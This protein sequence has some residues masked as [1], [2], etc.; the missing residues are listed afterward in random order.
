MVVGSGVCKGMDREPIFVRRQRKSLRHPHYDNHADGVYY[1]TVAVQGY[2]PLLGCVRGGA[3]VCSSA[4]RMVYEVWCQLPVRF[5][6]V[7]LDAFVVMPNHVHGILWLGNGPGA[8]LGEVIGAFKSMSTLRYIE[9]V[10][11]KG[12]PALIEG[13]G[14]GIIGIPVSVTNATLPPSA[15]TSGKTPPNMAGNR[16]CGSCAHPA[17][18]MARNAKTGIWQDAE[19]CENRIWQDA[20]EC[21]NRDLAGCRGMRKSGPAQDRPLRGASGCDGRKG[22]VRM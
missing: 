13:S 7:H 14:N 3:M 15:D 6:R 22:R 16:T 17:F 4:G 2:Q 21:E 5:S 11:H 12:W 10:H 9:C 19:E 8:G 18:R 1:I 20:E